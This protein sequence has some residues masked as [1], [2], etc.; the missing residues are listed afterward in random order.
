M[1]VTVTATMTKP[2]GTEF[3]FES[4][5]DNAAEASTLNS[6]VASLPGFISQTKSFSDTNTKIVVTVWDTVEN[7]ANAVA[8]RSQRPES[9]KKRAHNQ[10]NGIRTVIN[11]TLT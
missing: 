4:N 1:T 10:A 3:F 11:E 8:E 6:W 5:P 2:E 9:V 7:Y